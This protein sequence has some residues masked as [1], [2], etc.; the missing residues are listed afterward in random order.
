MASEEQER[1]CPER[2]EDAYE[3][4]IDWLLAQTRDRGR[5]ELLFR[6]NITYGFRRNIWALKSWAF[7][8]AGVAV[9][10]I[11]V[12]ISNIWTGELAVA[13]QSVGVQIWACLVLNLGHILIFAFM[14]RKK[15]VRLAA[16]AYARQLLA[17][18]DALESERKS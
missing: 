13:A 14:V 12:P 1:K 2:A 3:S 10:S 6:E 16:E 9:A 18:C 4:A 7:V 15:W 11:A 5:F 17:T 8:T